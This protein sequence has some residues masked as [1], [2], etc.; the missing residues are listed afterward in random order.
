MK[1]VALNLILWLV[2]FFVLAELYATGHEN[3]GIAGLAVWA[4][5]IFARK[6]FGESE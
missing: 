5:V 6:K 2:I 3:W 1:K 4:A